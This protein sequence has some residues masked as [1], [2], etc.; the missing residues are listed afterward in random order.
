MQQYYYYLL[1]N[2]IAALQQY[3]YLLVNYSCIDG[4]KLITTM[5]R[6]SHGE[7]IVDAICHQ[8]PVDSTWNRR[9]QG[10]LSSSHMRSIKISFLPFT[11]IVFPL[12]SSIPHLSRLLYRNKPIAP[13]C[14]YLTPS[15][16]D[17][18]CTYDRSA[19]SQ[20]NMVQY[21]SALPNEYHVLHIVNIIMT[22]ALFE[23]NLIA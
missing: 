4:T 17:T 7:L 18:G 5:L 2:Y 20:C 15:N 21:T 11:S 13:F 22:R 16:G 3:Y 19:V 10:L 6:L 1:V 9:P 23:D 12:S 14:D 8:D